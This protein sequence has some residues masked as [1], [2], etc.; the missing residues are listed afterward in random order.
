MTPRATLPTADAMN[1]TER[2]Y[3]DHLAARKLAGEV[4]GFWFEP[5]SVRLAGNTFYR[6]DFLVVLADGS[7]EF[8]ETKGFMRED[9]L[10]KIK[11]FAETYPFPLVLVKKQ[12]GGWGFTRY[13]AKR[14]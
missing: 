3:A 6:P 12:K 9:A 10:V 13:E 11:V 5:F 1:R 4:H 2:A 14:R 7:V 8:H